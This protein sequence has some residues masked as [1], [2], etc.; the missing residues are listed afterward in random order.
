MGWEEAATGV[1]MCGCVCARARA[2]GRRG[3]PGKKKTS[4][5]SNC[6]KIISP[7]LKE[8]SPHGKAILGIKKKK[9]SSKRVGGRLARRVRGVAR[10]LCLPAGIF[11]SPSRLG[12]TPSPPTHLPAAASAPPAVPRPARPSREGGRPAVGGAAKVWRRG[13][14]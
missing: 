13:L 3:A 8:G 1:C 6:V 10:Y 2:L 7:W 11:L 14:I 5:R 9:K 4:R 12:A